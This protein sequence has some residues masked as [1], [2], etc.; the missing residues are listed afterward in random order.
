MSP[1]QRAASS[2][3]NF[4]GS[5]DTD[6]RNRDVVKHRQRNY[7]FALNSTVSIDSSYAGNETRFVNHVSK[8]YANSSPQV[9]LVNGEHRIGIFAGRLILLASKYE[10]HRGI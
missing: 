8:P 1:P 4:Q 6:I 7:V 10:A 9:W 5:A 3:S 2:C